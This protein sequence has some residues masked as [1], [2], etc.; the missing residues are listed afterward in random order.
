MNNNYGTAKKVYWQSLETRF[1]KLKPYSQEANIK[2]V[3][4]LKKFWVEAGNIA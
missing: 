1:L 4:F 2:K 3:I